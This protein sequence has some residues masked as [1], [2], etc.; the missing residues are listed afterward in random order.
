VTGTA[1]ASS[2]PASRARLAGSTR[3]IAI[4]LLNLGDLA[5]VEGDHPRAETQLCQ[6]LELFHQLQDANE[7]SIALENLALLAGAGGLAERSAVLFGAA[8]AQRDE[9][10]AVL[11][12]VD[13]P[14]HDRAVAAITLRL[15]REAVV[16]AGA[17]GR[18][19]SREE[20]L[21]MAQQAQRPEPTVLALV[22]SSGAG[23]SPLTEREREVA[24]L[25][26]TGLTNKQI[27][28]TLVIT[29]Q[30]ADKHVGNILGKLGVASRAQVAVWWI[31]HATFAPAP[32]AA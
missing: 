23:P 32:A 2:E 15:G 24:A 11:P 12:P 19:L 20:A 3:R 17:R 31:Q 6:S 26:A 8:E 16:T 25:V 1:D 22:A 4:A 18:A 29:K 7:S 14:E 21:A 5:R 9:A 10:G 13:R 30:T 27:A 28:D